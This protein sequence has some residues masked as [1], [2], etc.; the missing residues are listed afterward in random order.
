MPAERNAFK[1][2]FKKFLDELKAKAVES[3]G[4]EQ[5]S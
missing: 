2:A 3:D 4:T 1:D 5:S